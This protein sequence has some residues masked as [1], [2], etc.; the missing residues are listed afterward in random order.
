MS[1]PDPKTKLQNAV[2]AVM[3]GGGIKTVCVIDDAFAGPSVADYK[4]EEFEEF[5]AEIQYVEEAI[6][7]LS[8]LGLAIHSS[9]D[10]DQNAL[11]TLEKNRSR[12]VHLKPAFE[13][14]LAPPFDAKLKPVNDL[15]DCLH[16][17]LGRNVVT[18]DGT[19]GLNDASIRLVFLDYFL[20]EGNEAESIKKVSAVAVEIGRRFSGGSKPLI[21]LMSSKQ[22]AADSIARLRKEAGFL[23]SMFEF[24]AKKEF[25]EVAKLSITLG[26]IARSLQERQRIQ[27][28]IEGVENSIDT[29]ATKLRESLRGL[30]F[31]DYA[32]IQKLSLQREGHPLGDYISW[33]YSSYFGH[34]LFESIPEQRTL[35][36]LT[37]AKLP[38][39]SFEPSSQFEEIYKN[40]VTEG[41][42]PLAG[43][44]RDNRAA[45]ADSPPFLHFG[46]VFSDGRGR[47]LMLITP[48]CDLAFTPDERDRPFDPEKSILLIPGSLS[49]QNASVTAQMKT[50]FFSYKNETKRIV[51]QPKNLVSVPHGEIRDWLRSSG[52]QRESRL[53]LPFA[54]EV[55]QSF[56]ADLTRIGMPV[57]PPIYKPAKLEIACEGKDKKIEVLSTLTD[58]AFIF[59]AR[60]D[61][62]VLSR[63][64]IVELGD[65]ID[66]AINVLEEAKKS[67][68]L[69]GGN[70]QGY[71]LRTAEIRELRTNFASLVELSGPFTL[72]KGSLPLKNLPVE[73]YRNHSGEGNYASKKAL[74][75]NIVDPAVAAAN[76]SA[77][78]QP[79]RAPRE[80]A[81]RSE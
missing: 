53:R 3:D 24:M 59:R 73:I 8:G 71:D 26:C 46:D 23:G 21:L 57:G 76:G 36:A 29:A 63:T 16:K 58:A 5:W 31:E 44:P 51:W 2:A 12:L 38:S 13:K 33:L 14:H 17:D 40:I 72:P 11:R 80:E 20:E 70:P 77:A 28:F 42:E 6:A 35:D 27:K 30:S 45:E 34:L 78:E 10:L 19:E 61:E 49:A 9:A 18:N 65:I 25:A 56:A 7:E 66:K 47:I 15:C 67:H 1:E 62:F 55:Q 64:C 69:K 50:D 52:Y 37:F 75:F 79:A 41:A 43:H 32:Y 48:E 22:I 39:T 60:E 4:A 54:L 74:M 68:V 81:K